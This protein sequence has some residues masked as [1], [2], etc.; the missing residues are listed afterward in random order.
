VSWIFALLPAFQPS[1]PQGNGGKGKG[2]GVYWY[3]FSNLCTR[4]VHAQK[5]DNRKEMQELARQQDLSKQASAGRITR[6][7][8]K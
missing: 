5:S 4:E 3:L 1:E 7:I 2:G 6:E 8:L